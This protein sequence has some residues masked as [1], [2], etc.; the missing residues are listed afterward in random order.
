MNFIWSSQNQILTKPFGSR[1]CGL[2][3]N[4]ERPDIIQFSIEETK[5]YS[6]EYIIKY[7]Q[8]VLMRSLAK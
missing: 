7:I 5:S 3:R 1:A 8:K 2:K 4:G 6:P